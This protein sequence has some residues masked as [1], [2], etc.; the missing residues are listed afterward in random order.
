VEAE[1]EAT[2]T[3]A[4]TIAVQEVMVGATM[5]GLVTTNP[6]DSRAA[7]GLRAVI[8]IRT[9]RAE[10]TTQTRMGRE[11]ETTT[12]GIV[13]VARTAAAITTIRTGLVTTNPADSRAAMG[14]QAVIMI[15]TGR[16]EAT[17][18]TRM[19]REAET[20]T[21]I[22]TA[23]ATRE[24][25]VTVARTVAAITTI[26][27][28]L[29]TTSPADSL[30]DSLAATGAQ[31]ETTLTRTARL[32]TRA[33]VTNKARV[34]AA[35]ATSIKVSITLLKRPDLISVRVQRARSAVD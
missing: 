17:T 9:G 28:G 32:E 12:Q 1:A 16:V 35:T 22:R 19:G 20:T 33:P 4:T 29:V 11:A 30:V 23:L 10:A 15:R 5:T 31:G 8:M 26:R 7:M 24:G 13:T 34:R 27:T 2:M 25:I 18:Q 21:R 6:A 14:L 3:P